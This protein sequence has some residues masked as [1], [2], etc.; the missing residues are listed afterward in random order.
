MDNHST[1]GTPAFLAEL[2]GDVKVITNDENLGFAKAC[3]Q[4]ARAARGEFL[5]FLNNDTIPLKGWLSAPS[6][7]RFKTHPDVA[8][9]GSKLLFEDRSVQHAGV[10][11]S[12]ECS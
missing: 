6:W 7:T 3:N 12:R 4:G 11:F 8:V 2:G 9:V 5:V 10:A 1:D